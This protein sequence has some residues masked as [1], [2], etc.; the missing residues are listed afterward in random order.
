MPGVVNTTS[1]A[2]G[3]FQILP[4]HVGEPAIT[5]PL[6]DPQTNVNDAFVL[7]KRAGGTFASDWAASATNSAQL[8]PSA[9]AEVAKYHPGAGG[10]AGFTITPAMVGI[11]LLLLLVVLM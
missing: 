2:T 6:T 10:G 4:G 1:G 3:L 8:L 7:W 9:Q 5:G 11:A